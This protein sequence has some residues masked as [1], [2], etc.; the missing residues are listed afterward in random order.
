VFD[1]VGKDT[2]MASLDSLSRR[3]DVLVRNASGAV[4]PQSPGILH[5]KARST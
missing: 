2:W 5:A 4:A 1:G 3:P